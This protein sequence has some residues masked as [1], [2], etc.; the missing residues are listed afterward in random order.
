MKHHLPFQIHFIASAILL[1]VFGGFGLGAYLVYSLAFEQSLSQAFS[2]MIQVHG[3][4]QL[5]GWTG[6]FIIGISLF[7]LPRLMSS[8]KLSLNTSRAIF[9]TLVIG[10]ILK[11]LAQIQLFSS[12]TETAWRF[13]VMLGSLLESLGILIYFKVFIRNSLSY[14]AQGGAYAAAGIKP[15][16]VVSLFGWFAYALINSVVGV[17]FWLGSAT[18]LSPS[19]N[20]IAVETYIHGVLLPTCF[21]FSISTF[22]IFLRLRA[23][24]WPVAKVAVLYGVGTLIYLIGTI[25]ELY[26]LVESS[27]VLSSIGICLRILATFWFLF[28]LDLLRIQAPW[29][30]KF[31]S[32]PDRENRPPRRFASDYGQFGNFE[33]LIYIAYLWLVV[34]L[35]SEL[36]G[37]LLDS[38]PAPNIVRHFYLLGFVT[39]LILGM[40]P[41]IIPGFLGKN[42]VAHP[43]LVRLSFALI[44]FATLSR[45]LPG[46]FL[47]LDSMLVRM[48]YG[49]SGIVAIL[50][51]V[52]LGINIAITVAQI[53]PAA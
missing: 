26:R 35:L 46:Q 52:V 1:G 8:R 28:E 12:N 20:Q 15:F 48:S 37:F 27:H 4:L 29:F 5:L 45:T 51:I 31:R 16:L 30:K 24:V 13:L 34:G 32:I 18:I 43:V 38:A 40:A 21:A 2:A 7:K 14:R 33:W 23:P 17:E 10:L 36:S 25:A 22:P 47:S 3:H 42:R 6:L 53:R 49:F 11:S 44:F 41:R 9:S 19:L 50:A 39:H